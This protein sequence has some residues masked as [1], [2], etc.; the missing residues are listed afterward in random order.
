MFI[1]AH[2][3]RRPWFLGVILSSQAL[4]RFFAIVP[5]Y[6]GEEKKKKERRKKKKE[7]TLIKTWSGLFAEASLAAFFNA[8]EITHLHQ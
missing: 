3:F 6:G 8:L 2:V 7:T 4:R 5:I 1:K